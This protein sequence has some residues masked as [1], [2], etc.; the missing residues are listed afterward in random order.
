L[1]LEIA[2]NPGGELGLCRGTNFL[3]NNRTVFKENQGWNSTDTMFRRNGG[4]LIDIEFGDSVF[5]DIR[6]QSLPR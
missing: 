5:L 4:I 1:E 6:Q 2:V 3:G